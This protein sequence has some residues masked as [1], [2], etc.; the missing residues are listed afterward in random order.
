MK[1]VIIKTGRF[2][3]ITVKTEDIIRFPLGLLGF[4]ELTEYCLIDPGDETL[5]LWLQSLQQP[6]VAFPVIEPRVFKTDYIVRLSAS[7]LR[8]LKLANVSKAA[9]Y[10][11][12]TIPVNV[13]EM[14][15]NMKAPL[16][17]NLNEGW[18]RQVVLQENEYSIKHPMFKELRTHL[19][20]IE[21]QRRLDDGKHGTVVVSTRSLSP[22][23]N[24]RSLQA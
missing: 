23:T 21:N 13:M 22:A 5:I 11:I 9:V 6:Q 7:E 18:A 16:V 2:G 20:T 8:D 15:A 1:E 3:E 17:I 14:T 24:V 12:L 4:Q 10:N 19:L